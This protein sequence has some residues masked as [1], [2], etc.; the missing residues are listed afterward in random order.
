[1]V[2]DAAT[3]IAAGKSAGCKTALI[4]QSGEPLSWVDQPDIRAG[5]LA[6]AAEQ[7]LCFAFSIGVAHRG[8]AQ[9]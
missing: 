6:S 4:T 9:T 1:M 2:G 3:D 8:A 7:I 5:S